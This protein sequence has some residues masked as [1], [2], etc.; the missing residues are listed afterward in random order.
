MT[1]LPYINA[2]YSLLLYGITGVFH[3]A[4]S[5]PMPFA[6]SIELTNHCN[7]QCPCCTTGSGIL[8]RSKGF[9][10]INTA[11][12]IADSLKDY[13]LSANLYFQGEPMLH[14]QFFEIV[15]ILKGLHGTISTNG[16]FLSRENCRKLAQSGLKKIIVSYDGVSQDT[17]STYRKGGDINKVTEG[18]KCLAE[19]IKKRKR[20]P[21]IELLF[22][23]GRHNG[24]EIKEAEAFARSVNALF[25]VKSMQ[26]L[27]PEDIEQWI[28]P[29]TRLSRYVKAGDFYELRRGPKRGCIRVWT[30][31]VITWDGN[32]IPCC[33][34]KD[35]VFTFG[36]LNDRP[37]HEIW[38]SKYRRSFISEVRKSRTLNKICSS[39]PQ[40]LKLFFRPPK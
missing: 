12:K 18:I 7:L 29:E 14:P 15:E 4:V 24:H 6:V 13:V 34:D 32:V 40:G 39:C 19:E 38:N 33:Y 5:S 27:N 26:V 3:R 10:D 31:A 23:Y 36:N 17:Y 37:L 20:A 22:L 11:E 28:P 25:S 16:H 30:T 2:I 35:A 8:K 9:M 1:L 21:A